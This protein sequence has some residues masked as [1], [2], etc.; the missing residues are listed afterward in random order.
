MGRRKSKSPDNWPH[1]DQRPV[2]R[3]PQDDA[4]SEMFPEGIDELAEEV[5]VEGD[6]LSESDLFDED[7][8]P[9]EDDI[10]SQN[11]YQ[12]KR[13]RNFRTAAE[14]VARAL[15]QLPEVRKVVLFGSVSRPLKKEVPRFREYRSRGIEVLHECNDVDLAVWV[16]RLDGLKS[17]QKARSQALN[18]LLREANIGVA[19]QQVEIF[20]MEPGTDRYLGRLCC[21]GNCPK[22]KADCIAPRCGQKRF[23]KQIDGFKFR[24]D[25][26]DTDVILY[27][28]I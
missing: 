27:E 18:D 5:D 11:R 21:F 12:L 14:T 10:A 16:S 20:L 6:E 15:S 28:R 8:T 3:A 1:S 13:Q 2:D 22:G 9:D 24:K 26:L 7:A 17:L 19:H 4:L 25:A 23:L